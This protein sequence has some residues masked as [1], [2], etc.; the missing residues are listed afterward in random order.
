VHLVIVGAGFV[1]CE[2]AS[3]ARTLGADVTIVEAGTAPLAR[4]VG[5]EVGTLLAERIRAH[6]VELRL[7][8]TEIP[9]HDVLLWAT[10]V[11]TDRRL[12]PALRVDACG[13]TQYPHVYAAGD[14]TGT[15]HWTAAAAGQA[16]AAAHAILGDVRPFTEP[17]YIWSDQFGLRLNSSA[18]PATHR[19]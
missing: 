19:S 14:V 3:T 4:I 11:D 12:L 16:V 2:V 9:P 18:T 6:G 8:T 15:G 17:P 10:G 7:G 1:G 5:D 13:R